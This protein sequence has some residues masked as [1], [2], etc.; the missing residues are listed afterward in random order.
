MM[1][2]KLLATALCSNNSI[3]DKPVMCRG[4][5]L[6]LFILVPSC[7]DSVSNLE[8][9]RSVKLDTKVSFLVSYQG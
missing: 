4:N 3:F 7:S 2:E 9:S 6:V 8:L 1:L 5:Y